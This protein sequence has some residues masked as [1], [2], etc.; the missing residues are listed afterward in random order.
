LILKSDSVIPRNNERWYGSA[1]R[2]TTHGISKENGAQQFHRETLD[3]LLLLHQG[4][5][6]E[7]IFCFFT[8]IGAFCYSLILKNIF[9]FFYLFF[10]SIAEEKSTLG[11]SRTPININAWAKQKSRLILFCLNSTRHSTIASRHRAHA[12]PFAINVHWTFIERSVLFGRLVV[13]CLLNFY[14]K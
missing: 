12:G 5:R 4:K 3:F 8:K 9:S 13:S 2:S 7:I 11:D 1:V 10:F 14:E 6:W